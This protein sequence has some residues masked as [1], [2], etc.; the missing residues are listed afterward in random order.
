MATGYGPAGPDDRGEVDYYGYA[1]EP[2]T[3]R[4]RWRGVVLTLFL[5]SL[6]AGGFWFA[7]SA[8]KG[9]PEGEVPLIRADGRATKQ[10]PDQPG[11]MTIPD[12]DKLVYNQ[13]APAR[14]PERLLPPPEA[15]LPSPA[16]PAAPSLAAAEPA[17]APAPVEPAPVAP[18][19][20][21][22]PPIAAAPAPA[23]APPLAAVPPPQADI[24]APP[25]PPPVIAS[26]ATEAAATPP[27]VAVA[28]RGWRLQ[29]G[30]LRSEDAAAKEWEKLQAAN[31]DLLGDLSAI[32]PRADLGERGTFWR[33]Q[34]GPLPDQ[35][36]AERLCGE[37]KK[38]NLGCILVKP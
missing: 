25:P 23:P 22:A 27:P 38:R 9:R 33:L 29:L 36:A 3:P 35:T 10:R 6:F 30:A 32:W 18:P 13:G 21:A 19:P 14:Q 11:G 4:R 34:A 7:Y 15:P 26:P 2:A 37:L 20:V 24:A 1:E 17:P 28:G 12:Q 8:G 31:K 5:M 16:P